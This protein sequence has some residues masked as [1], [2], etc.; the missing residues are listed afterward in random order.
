M[1]SH[2]GLGVRYEIPCQTTPGRGCS[3]TGPC[4]ALPGTGCSLRS[5]VK[6]CQ[7]GGIAPGSPSILTG[8]GFS[9]RSLSG[10]A[11][12]GAGLKSPSLV[13][14]QSC[15]AG[16]WPQV[17]D[18][19]HSDSWEEKIPLEFDLHLFDDFNFFVVYSFSYTC[20]LFVYRLSKKC[21]VRFFDHFSVRSFVLDG[22]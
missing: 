18:S 14:G 1:R 12:Q 11:R 9:L 4:Q 20:W 16:V 7:V 15:Q 2:A 10:L 13:T 17:P 3:L 19:S 8:W 5:P 6:P 22:R 21:L